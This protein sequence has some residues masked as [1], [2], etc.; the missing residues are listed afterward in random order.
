MKEKIHKFLKYLS[1][2]TKDEAEFI[3]HI[4]S[5]T[6][7]EKAAFMFAKRIFEDRDGVEEDICQK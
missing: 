4:L 1:Q 2:L 3:E 5:W 6:D 7:E